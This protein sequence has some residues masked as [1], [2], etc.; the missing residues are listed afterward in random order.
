MNGKYICSFIDMWVF[1]YRGIAVIT[2]MIGSVMNAIICKLPGPYV[3]AINS[4]VPEQIGCKFAD[5]DHFS[6][7]NFMELP[8]LTVVWSNEL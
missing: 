3:W 1:F 4:L 7:A 8:F 2:L 5:S 6:K